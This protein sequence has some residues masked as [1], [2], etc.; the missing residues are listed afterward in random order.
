MNVRRTTTWVVLACLAV[1]PA[2]AQTAAPAPVAKEPHLTLEAAV[3][4]ALA[5]APGLQA[6]AA[7]DRAAQWNATAVGRARFG[8]LD[9]VFSYSRFQDDQILRPMS[10]QLFGA[11]GF[12]S[13][14]WDRDQAHYGV[15]FQVPVYTGGRLS[16][17]LRI[18]AIQAEQ[19]RLFTE[20]TRRDIR[21]NTTTLYAAVQTLDAVTVALDRSIDALASTHGRLTLMLE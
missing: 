15:T 17:S 5:N 16:S 1:S 6:A 14:P 11:Q 18:A 20:A 13:L 2:M 12:L 4:E 7:Q 10:K 21:S 8:Q 3:T 19:A 9:G